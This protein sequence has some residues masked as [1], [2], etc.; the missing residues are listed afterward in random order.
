MQFFH[1]FHA[2]GGFFPLI[3]ALAVLCSIVMRNQNP[4]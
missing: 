4:S 1:G 2:H 3:L